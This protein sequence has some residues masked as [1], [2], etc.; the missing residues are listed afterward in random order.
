MKSKLLL[1]IAL[2]TTLLFQTVIYAANTETETTINWDEV[3]YTCDMPIVPADVKA[4]KTEANTIT[5]TWKNT[6]TITDSYLKWGYDIY[7]KEGD[8]KYKLVKTIMSGKTQKYKLT[9]LSENQTYR[10]RIRAFKI[11]YPG[12]ENED[13]WNSDLTKAVKVNMKT[14]LLPSNLK[15]KKKLQVKVGAKKTLAVSVTKGKDT[16]LIKKIS[17]SSNK[18]K[19]ATVKSGV[20]KGKKKG[21]ATITTKVTLKS[22]LKKTFATKVRVTK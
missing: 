3:M 10:I 16:S 13:K 4:Y 22:G 21:T 8:G 6:N 15:V 18:P 7:L 12:T 14:Q 17:Y 1:S 11:L 20:I 9:G 2:I 5:V 19:V